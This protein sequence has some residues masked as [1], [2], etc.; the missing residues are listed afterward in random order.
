MTRHP[1]PIHKCGCSSASQV[2][3]VEPG[4]SFRDSGIALDRLFRMRKKKDTIAEK[5]TCTRCFPSA[6][7][8]WEGIESD[9]LLAC[10]ENKVTYVFWNVWC[11]WFS[12]QIGHQSTKKRYHHMYSRTHT[13]V[14]SSKWFNI[15]GQFFKQKKKSMLGSLASPLQYI[16]LSQLQWW[17]Y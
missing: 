1:S 4:D 12:H 10:D 17:V 13:Y 11:D 2:G 9:W 14:V 16:S 6:C 7:D 15:F 3:L 8:Y 5:T